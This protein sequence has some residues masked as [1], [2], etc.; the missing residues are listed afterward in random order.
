LVSFQQFID[1]LMVEVK[2]TE[3][4]IFRQTEQQNKTQS[5]N[6]RKDTTL[7]TMH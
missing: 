4:K 1:K 2:N 3:R 5:C 7:R 6:E